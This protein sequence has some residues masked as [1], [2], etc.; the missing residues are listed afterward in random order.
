MKR[1]CKITAVTIVTAFLFI[2]MCFPSYAVDYAWSE[3]YDYW[4]S[5]FFVPSPDYPN[6]D[7]L[8]YGKDTLIYEVMVRCRLEGYDGW[9]I[10]R[11]YLNED[12]YSG[13]DVSAF[14]GS[15]V[16][17][18]A[19]RNNNFEGF[20]ASNSTV[21]YQSYLYFQ[22]FGTGSNVYSFNNVTKAPY[23]KTK[24]GKTYNFYVLRGTLASSDSDYDK[25]FASVRGNAPCYYGGRDLQSL[26]ES[27]LIH[28]APSDELPAYSYVWC[29]TGS[30]R[31][32]PTS[33]DLSSI[34]NAKDN[35]QINNR[36]ETLESNVVQGFDK[37][38]D[39]VNQGV[40]K[41]QQAIDNAANNILNAGSD[42]PSLDTDNEWMNDSLTK[43]NEW[44]STLEEFDKQMD[45]A[46]EEN[47]ENMAQAKTFLTSFF[48]KIP[49]GI[50]AALTLALVMIVAVKAVGR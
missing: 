48:S 16:C 15:T 21:Y 20:V 38:N 39:S 41:I 5:A 46:E 26:V 19:D 29:L 47:A 50:I 7:S 40:T 10:H 44:L 37:V 34:Q 31:S 22:T 9:K 4:N 36:L 2:M 12:L 3:D 25:I 43:V 11:F 14:N 30:T 13:S 32:Y 17:F 42:M 28:N 24:D 8:P 49:K 1:L 27:G 6:A 33:G 45:A 18:V 35:E 23:Y